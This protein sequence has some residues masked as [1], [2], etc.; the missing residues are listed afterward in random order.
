MDSAHRGGPH[1]EGTDQ[2]VVDPRPR[3][4]VAVREEHQAQAQ[5]DTYRPVTCEGCDAIVSPIDSE[6]W[7]CYRYFPGDC[8][9]DQR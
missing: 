4:S 9:D 8:F 7:Q 2:R 1:N 6:C 5:R 3:P